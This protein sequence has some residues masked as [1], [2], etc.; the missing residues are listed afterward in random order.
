MR[1]MEYLCP[2]CKDIGFIL[3]IGLDGYEYA[4]PCKCKVMKE[5][6][7]RLERSGL[8][9]EFKIKSF[10]NYA[11]YNNKQL[12]DAK[13]TAMQYVDDVIAANQITEAPSMMLCGQVGA[14]K[15]HL[16]TACSVK[17]INKG[18]VVIYM[19]YR[20][21]MT[22][23]KSKVTDEAAYTR[24]INRYKTAPVLFVDDFLKGKITEA[25]VNVVYEIIN[26]R[27]NND[28]P[29]IIST[30]KTL[31][32]LIDYDEAIG[33]RLVEMCRGYIIVFND[34]KLNY[35]LYRGGEI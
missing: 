7:A 23:L 14:G 12:E 31:D 19:G 22:V 11:T 32:D 9:R 33:S 8:A 18:I 5:A 34:E 1:K 26:Y 6:K 3:D 17:L 16:G 35:R 13:D 2:Y 24:E 15:T 20:E 25:D 10:E 29:V 21:E 30:E 28:L 4:K 27:Y